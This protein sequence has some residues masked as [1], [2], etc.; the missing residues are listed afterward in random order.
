MKKSFLLWCSLFLFSS[1]DSK[2]YLDSITGCL[3]THRLV[4]KEKCLS[5]NP[6]S[7]ISN[8]DDVL[9]TV[10]DKGKTMFPQV[11]RTKKVGDSVYLFNDDSVFQLKKGEKSENTTTYVVNSADLSV[12]EV[13][14][15]FYIYFPIYLFDGY[16][17]P[18]NER[19]DCKEDFFAFKEFYEGLSNYK[20][21]ENSILLEK[22]LNP[23]ALL[24]KPDVYLNYENHQFWFSLE[25]GE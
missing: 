9:E 20:V 24:V 25:K 12:G 11:K 21:M 6:T 5:Y 3:S 10:S 4:L 23:G 14:Q 1:C 19:I 18:F 15:E 22:Y 13:K 17:V 7:F 2:M 8:R 16:L